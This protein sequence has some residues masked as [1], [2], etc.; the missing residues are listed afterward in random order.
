MEQSREVNMQL[1]TLNKSGLKKKNYLSMYCNE[2]EG[3]M[4]LQDADDHNS[5]KS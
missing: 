4:Y 2:K 1:N 5:S 3:R